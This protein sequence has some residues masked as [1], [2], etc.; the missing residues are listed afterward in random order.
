MAGFDFEFTSKPDEEDLQRQFLRWIQGASRDLDLKFSYRKHPRGFYAAVD[1]ALPAMQALP[2]YCYSELDAIVAVSS[3]PPDRRRR[4]R[5]LR[6]VL[7]AFEEG[8]DRMTE[9]IK[10]V[11]V[12]Q[13]AAGLTVI[14]RSFDFDPGSKTHLRASLQAF[15]LALI[16]SLIGQIT[17]R[18]LLEE[19]HTA[20]EHTMDALL[21]AKEK[22]DLSF[23]GKIDLLSERGVFD[24]PIENEEVIGGELVPQL[25]ELKDRRKESKHRAQ[26][27]DSGAIDRLATTATN[28]VHVLLGEIRRQ[29]RVA[30]GAPKTPPTSGVW[31]STG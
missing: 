2:I 17:N 31:S 21:T 9:G 22:K 10:E 28:G 16:Q 15:R 18:A 13:E 7:D 6:R 20:I 5:I 4:R 25:K 19:C 24:L 23:E 11:I 1:G 14:P 3:N 8:L 29:D 26:V 12:I 30:A 27:V